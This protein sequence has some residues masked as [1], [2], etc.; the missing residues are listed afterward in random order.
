MLAVE[1]LQERENI[2]VDC[3]FTLI[4]PEEMG[5]VYDTDTKMSLMEIPDLVETLFKSIDLQL[6][7]ILSEDSRRK[8]VAEDIQQL[9]NSY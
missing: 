4:V 2:T 7:L 3:V 9:A 8:M 5:R 6:T 1:A